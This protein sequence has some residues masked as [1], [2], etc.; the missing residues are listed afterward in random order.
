MHLL[1][2]VADR[3]RILEGDSWPNGRHVSIL[4]Q[5]WRSVEIGGAGSRNNR[6]VLGVSDLHQRPLR[7]SPTRQTHDRRPLGGAHGSGAL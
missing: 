5:R 6:S 1:L 7:A 2:P 4:R 3:A